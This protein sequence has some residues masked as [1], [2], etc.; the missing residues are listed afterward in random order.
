M[1]EVPSNSLPM[2]KYPEV[3]VFAALANAGRRHL[4][5]RMATA[6][7][8]LTAGEAGD[9]HGK[10]RNLMVKNLAALRDAGL[11]LVAD[12]ENDGRKMRYRLAPG[13]VLRRAGE[14][15]E[16]DFGSGVLRWTAGSESRAFPRP[17]VR[18]RRRW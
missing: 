10:Q 18:N 16:L 12:D 11:V 8:S 3:A 15:Y 7:G 17:L 1:S 14:D 6:G 5:K 2:T 9:G 4:L 13:I